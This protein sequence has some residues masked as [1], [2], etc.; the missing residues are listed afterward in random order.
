[1]TNAP[2]DEKNPKTWVL[3]LSIAAQHLLLLPA[4]PPKVLFLA[5]WVGWTPVAI[6]W[7]LYLAAP[8]IY[9]R[10]WTYVTILR[11]YARAGWLFVLACAAWDIAYISFSEKYG[12]PA[13]STK[14][15]EYHNHVVKGLLKDIPK[16]PKP[17]EKLP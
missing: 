7:A 17:P 8:W 4:K 1:M 15:Q 12:A 16:T 5:T 3:W 9:V 14:M 13:N 2:L 6:I 10:P 11:S